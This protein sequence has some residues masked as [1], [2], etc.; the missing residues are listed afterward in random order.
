[1]P[2]PLSSAGPTLLLQPTPGSIVPHRILCGVW[3]TLEPHLTASLERK[4]WILKR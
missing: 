4:T 3:F 2:I 1:M